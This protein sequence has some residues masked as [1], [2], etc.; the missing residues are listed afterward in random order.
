MKKIDLIKVA[1]WLFATAAISI[2]CCYGLIH[3]AYSD[4]ETHRDSDIY[5]QQIDKRL[6]DIHSELIEIDRKINQI[7]LR[8]K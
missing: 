3:F 1:Q 4:F 6:D 8:E 5:R 2:S 7:L